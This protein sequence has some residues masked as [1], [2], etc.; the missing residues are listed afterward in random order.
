MYNNVHG[1]I[2]CHGLTLETMQTILI[3][4]INN[5]WWAIHTMEGYTAIKYGKMYFPRM[6]SISSGLQ[7]YLLRVE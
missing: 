6:L 5:I 7:I 1:K 4:R 3:N 2:I